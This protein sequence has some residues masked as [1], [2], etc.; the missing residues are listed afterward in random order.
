LEVGG[1][2]VVEVEVEELDWRLLV[3]LGCKVRMG[4]VGLCKLF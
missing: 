1:E 4:E 3:G 2:V